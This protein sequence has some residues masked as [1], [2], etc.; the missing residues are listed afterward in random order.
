MRYALV[1]IETTGGHAA[2]SRIT[3]V[4]INIHEGNRVIERYHQ[5]I[6]PQQSIPAYITALT[7]IDNDLVAHAGPFSAYAEEIFNLLA[8]KVFVAHNV[9]FDYSFLKHQLDLCGYRL[10]TPKLCTVRLS[11]KLIP[12]QASY[13]LG[14]LCNSLN[15]PIIDRHRAQG[16]ADATSILFNRLLALDDAAVIPQM[17]KKNSKEQALPPHLERKIFL[18]L[19]EQ[20]GVYYFKDE[21]GKVIYVGK[22]KNIKKRV[23]SH[24]SGHQIHKQ[25]QDFHKRI[26]SVAHQICGTELIALILEAHEIKK[27]WPDNNR[28][29]KRYEYKYDL[30]AYDDQNGYKRLAIEKHRKN[31]VS[32]SAF[33]QLLEAQNFLSTFCREHELCAKLC[34]L[35]KQNC[36]SESCKGACWGTESAEHYNLRVEHALNNLKQQLPSFLLV[37]QGRHAQEQSYIYIA[38]GHFKGIAYVDIQ[39]AENLNTRDLIQRLQPYHSNDYII[40]LILKTA[41]EDPGKLIFTTPDNSVL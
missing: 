16:D 21:K 2:N 23:W 37:D 1:D 25:R 40:N 19:P 36:K 17:L 14:K 9:N 38:E 29:M 20:A 7:G 33:N 31:H 18:D 41:L 15:I 22:A 27:F 13:S 24:F 35:Q 11:R 34:L 3:E 6:N 5:L 30:I 4:A 10:Q 32:L 26:H 28:A 39:E 8:D 12:H